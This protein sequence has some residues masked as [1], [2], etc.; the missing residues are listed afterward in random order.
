MNPTDAV[1][2]WLDRLRADAEQAP[3]A[4]LSVEGLRLVLGHALDA[5]SPTA[6]RAALEQG[7]E[8]YS[9][10]GYVAAR[11]VLTAPLEWC[12]LLLAHGSRVHLKHPAGAPG[13]APWL[14][15]HAEAVGLP[16]TASSHREPLSS[17]ELVIAMGSDA[18]LRTLAARYGQVLGF[19]HRVSLAIL[20]QNTPRPL[21]D[22]LAADLAAHDGRGCMSPCLVLTTDSSLSDPLAEAMAAAQV[23]WPRGS[24]SDGE[25]AALR[26]RR[27]LARA[28]GRVHEGQGWS[29]HQL[30]LALVRPVSLPRSAQVAVV[31]GLMDALASLTPSFPPLS[32]LSAPTA[33][34]HALRSL[35]PRV[36][37]LGQMQRPPLRRHHDGVEHL[38][39]I[40][41]APPAP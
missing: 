15:D 27:A 4:P 6:L 35:A 24:L 3:H 1:L 34:H 38:R 36:C 31:P 5:I 18:T 33:L 9:Q 14:V 41:K 11:S 32:T 16:L 37:E 26:T 20:P 23:R 28:A 30:P 21:I 19:G 8:A 22:A 25:H 40:T 12:A 13:L 39:A 17:A 2:A 29:V 7:G 10:V